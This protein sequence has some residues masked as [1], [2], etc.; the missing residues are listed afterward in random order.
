MEESAGVASRRNR[1]RKDPAKATQNGRTRCR[2]LRTRN[3]YS[4]LEIK[5]LTKAESQTSILW[6][7]DDVPDPAGENT[8][9]PAIVKHTSLFLAG[10]GH[11][12]VVLAGVEWPEAVT[13]C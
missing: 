2:L 6:T 10:L 13:S 9:T 5:G 11:G 7:S 12:L 4:D 1:N 3:G 8:N